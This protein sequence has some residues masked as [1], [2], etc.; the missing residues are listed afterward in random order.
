MLCANTREALGVE[1]ALTA[2]SIMRPIPVLEAVPRAGDGHLAPHE[3]IATDDGRVLK[4]DAGGHELDHTWTGQ[5][6]ILWDLAGALA[7]WNLDG[8]GELALLDGFTAAHGCRCAPLA[9]D[10]YRIAYAAHRFGQVRVGA[11]ME[12]EPEERARLESEAER[13]REILG[14]CLGALVPREARV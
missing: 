6:P 8:A 7:E 12:R 1:A 14:S 3:W 5:Q 10:A 13:W 11:D 9:L 2:L 4:T